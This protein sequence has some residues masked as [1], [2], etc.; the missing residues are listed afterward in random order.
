M[1]IRFHRYIVKETVLKWAKSHKD[2]SYKGHKIKMFK[3][4]STDL[5]RKHEAFNKVKSLFYKQ[6]ARSGMLYPVRFQITC[7]GVE[8]FDSPEEAETFHLQNLPN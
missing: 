4:F 8:L 5:A 3:D 6:G 1:I 2:S 7:N